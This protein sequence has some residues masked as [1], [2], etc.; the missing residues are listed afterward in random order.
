MKKILFTICV[1]L[2]QISSSAQVVEPNSV[3]P[4]DPGLDYAQRSKKGKTG[5]IVLL[6]AGLVTFFAGA[7]TISNNLFSEN[8]EGVAAASIG[9]VLVVSSI[10]LFII[11]GVNK[12]KSR[13]LLRKENVHTYSGKDIS[14]RAAVAWRIEF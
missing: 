5:A 9:T 2:L 1:L 11:S 8:N 4:T 7:S 10:P 13:I 6:S 12:R 14:Q 3:P